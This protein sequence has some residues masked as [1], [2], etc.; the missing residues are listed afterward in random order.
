MIHSVESIAKNRYLDL[1]TALRVAE[2]SNHAFKES[3]DSPY[4]VISFHVDAFVAEVK[5]AQGGDE[6][7]NRIRER[8][9]ARQF[10]GR[11]K[12]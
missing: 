6:V 10:V 2:T 11:V 3:E 4:I 12:R 5:A 8:E 1:P 9:I 7:S